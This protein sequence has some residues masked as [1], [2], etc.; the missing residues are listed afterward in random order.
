MKE[1]R[2]LGLFLSDRLEEAHKVQGILTK[3]GCNIKTRL[4]LHEVLDG[5][6]STSGLIILELTG[7]TVELMKLENELLKLDG[8]QVKKMIF[9][10]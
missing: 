9:S 8:L 10:V 2:I 4:G 1:L 6:C 5:T 3:F 7:N